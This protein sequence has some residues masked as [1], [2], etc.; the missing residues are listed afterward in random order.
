MIEFFPCSNVQA[1]LLCGNRRGRNFSGS[2]PIFC[3]CTH[4]VQDWTTPVKGRRD[5]GPDLSR[6]NVDGAKMEG[7]HLVNM[8]KL[9]GL[10]WG[11]VRGK[12]A[13][14]SALPTQYSASRACGRARCR[15]HRHS[16]ATVWM[17]L[18]VFL[19]LPPVHQ[20]LGHMILLFLIPHSET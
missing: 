12:Q 14:S 4:G 18:L 2:R 5:S 9:L 7:A 3:L 10:V 13:L 11:E 16:Q 8:C 1:S 20:L 19:L 6:E 17:H 15:R